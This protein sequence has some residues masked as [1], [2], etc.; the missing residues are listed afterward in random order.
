M[1]KKRREFRL[2]END[3]YVIIRAQ[4]RRCE[5]RVCVRSSQGRNTP[6]RVWCRSNKHNPLAR[7][8]AFPDFDFVSK[9]R[10]VCVCRSPRLCE[11]LYLCDVQVIDNHECDVDLF[12]C[13]RRRTP[14]DENKGDDG[15]AWARVR[16]ARPAS[17]QDPQRGPQTGRARVIV[18]VSSSSLLFCCSAP[19]MLIVLSHSTTPTRRARRYS[20]CAHWCQ[21]PRASASASCSNGSLL[22]NSMSIDR[23]YYFST[24]SYRLPTNVVSFLFLV[25][26]C[27]LMFVCCCAPTTTA[28]RAARHQCR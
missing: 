21:C 22:L 6:D 5:A 9:P 7:I 3:S 13:Q 28:R 2:T 11:P 26:R 16:G 27:V 12:G 4:R 23:T 15:V 17:R 10:F 1:G 25:T 19:L 14:F 24:S 20:R 18:G 8:I